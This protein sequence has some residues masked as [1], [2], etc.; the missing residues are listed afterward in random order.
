MKKVRGR[1]GGA[2]GEKRVRYQREGEKRERNFGREG[3]RFSE[4]KKKKIKYG[5]RNSQG[6]KEKW[7]WG[8]VCASVCPKGKH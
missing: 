6:E 4:E 3:G 1:R 8:P 7:R 5:D 2:G